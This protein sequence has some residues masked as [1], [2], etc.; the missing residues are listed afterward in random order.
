MRF[1]LAGPATEG[2]RLVVWAIGAES[3]RRY[4]AWEV[5]KIKVPFWVPQ[6]IGAAL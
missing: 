2:S 6:K 3:V 1:L 4:L 5:V